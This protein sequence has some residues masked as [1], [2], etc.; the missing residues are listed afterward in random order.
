MTEYRKGDVCSLEVTYLGRTWNSAD[1]ATLATKSGMQF[2]APIKDLTFIRHA[3]V[4]LAGK[5]GG[6]E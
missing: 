6:D 1:H 4:D 5:G 2:R 3:P